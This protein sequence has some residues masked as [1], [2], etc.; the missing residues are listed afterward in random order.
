MQ[1]PGGVEFLLISK[2]LWPGAGRRVQGRLGARPGGIIGV[3]VVDVAEGQPL[4]SN[5]VVWR[6]RVAEEVADGE[7][8]RRQASAIP[9]GSFA[10]H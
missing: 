4:R 1:A 8:S 2:S 7:R 3:I 6:E 9:P 5:F 10:R